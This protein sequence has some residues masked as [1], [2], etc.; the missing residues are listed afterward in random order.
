M[1]IESDDITWFDEDDFLG[2][3]TSFPSGSVWR[4]ESKIHEHSYYEEQ[5]ECEAL[6]IHSEARGVFSCSKVSGNGPPTAVIKMRLQIP[7]WRTATKKPEVR[8]KQATSETPR[9]FSSEIEALSHLTKSGCSSYKLS[10]LMEKLPGSDP[11]DSLFSGQM[12]RDER[13]SLRKAFKEA[14][15]ETV[16]CGVI[17][18][19]GSIN[20]LLWDSESE[21]CYLVDWEYWRLSKDT[22]CWEDRLYIR[23]NLAQDGPS[24]NLFDMSDWQL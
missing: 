9:A 4:L 13:D 23:W 19:D 22:T 11:G 16:R 5:S 8:A 21:R 3:E 7:W 24:H 1:A 20:N 15:L 6:G 10:I 17:H 18:G 12:P 2:T 14:W